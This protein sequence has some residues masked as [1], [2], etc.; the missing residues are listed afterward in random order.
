MDNPRNYDVSEKVDDIE[1]QYPEDLEKRNIVPD[2]MQSVIIFASF[3]SM[4]VSL[5]LFA[6]FL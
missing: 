2:L 5:M 6:Q 3:F 4:A 1:R